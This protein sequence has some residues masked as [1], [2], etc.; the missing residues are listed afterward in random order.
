[1][2]RGVMIA[3]PG[4]IG[5]MVESAAAFARAGELDRYL[6]PIA[7]TEPDVRKVERVLLPRS[8]AKRVATELRRRATPPEV[9]AH[10]A[11]TGTSLELANVFLQR[12]PLPMKWR[13]AMF[14]PRMIG[15]DFAVSRRLNRDVGAVIGYQGA[16]VHTFRRARRLGV[17]TVL[18]YPIAHYEIAQRTLKEEARLVPDYASTLIFYD[19]WILERY[20]EEIRTA[21]KI[22]VLSR[23]QQGTF[24][25]AGVAADRMFIAP[26]GADL[27]MFT[28]PEQE[29]E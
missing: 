12:T 11:R 17:P 28:P 2:S 26:L 7:I 24:E 25:E 14:K 13:R 9:G 15:F 1:M 22:I 10:L 20:E 8:F 16:A 3:N 18:D 4:A 21:E 5:W 27:E 6:A 23:Y 19:D 29:P